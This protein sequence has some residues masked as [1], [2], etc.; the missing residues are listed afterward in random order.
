MTHVE[1]KEECRW[2]MHKLTQ[3]D[4]EEEEDQEEEGVDQ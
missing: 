4:W 3:V 1:E 2:M